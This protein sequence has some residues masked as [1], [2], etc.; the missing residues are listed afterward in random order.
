[1]I[2]SFV[3]PKKLSRGCDFSRSLEARKVE[4]LSRTSSIKFELDERKDILEKGEELLAIIMCVLDFRTSKNYHVR[5][6]PLFFF[7]CEWS[8]CP[9]FRMTYWCLQG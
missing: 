8:R 1:M 3:L 6:I 9:P 4:L 7:V 2:Q 5:R